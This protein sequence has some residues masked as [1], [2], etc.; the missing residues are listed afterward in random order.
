MKKL[1]LLC[2]AVLSASVMP[3]AYAEVLAPDVLINNTA[4]EVLA[5]IK[6]DKDI[7]AGS[8]KRVLELVDAKVLPHFNFTRMTRLA[9]G[10]HWRT[11]T[12]EQ[13]KS[14]EAEFRNMLVRT[15]TKAFSAYRDQVV[16]IKPL[17]LAGDAIE[18]TVKT[19]IVK[20]GVP[21]TAVNYDME[22]TADGWKVYD[23]SVEGVS[24]I[25]S[26]R[27]TFS[28]QIQQ[29]G[30]DGLIKTLADKNRSAVDTALHKAGNK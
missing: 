5:I 25:T 6:Q 12:P 13:K 19:A 18:V 28:D 22:K 27:S 21:S 9:V 15:Y 11:A 14:L 17:K 3:V 24:L 10:K 30:I 2:L 4:K 29:G 16:Q 20:P 23:L 7:Q 26:Y 1:M 8:Q